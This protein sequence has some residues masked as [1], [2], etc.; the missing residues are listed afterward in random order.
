[1]QAGGLS[2]LDVHRARVTSDD[3]LDR[4]NPPKVGGYDMRRDDDLTAV[5]VQLPLAQPARGNGVGMQELRPVTFH[6]YNMS[7]MQS[8]WVA[9]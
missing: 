7:S 1:M 5:L 6:T 3:I 8:Y 9:D 2:H 4:G